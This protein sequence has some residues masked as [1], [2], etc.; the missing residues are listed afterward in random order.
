MAN[1]A[2][3]FKLTEEEI[4]DMKEVASVFHMTM[5]DLIKDAVKEYLAKMKQDPYYRLTANIPEASPEETREVL[6]AIEQL[7]DDDLSIVRSDT[8]EF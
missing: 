3:N 6:S 5:T 8:L 1:K 7:T 4:N 2:L